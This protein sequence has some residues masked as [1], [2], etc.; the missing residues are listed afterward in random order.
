MNSDDSSEDFICDE[1]DY[2]EKEF[3]ISSWCCEVL[4]FSDSYGSSISYSAVNI[5]GRPSKFPAYGDF[6][7]SNKKLCVSLLN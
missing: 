2:E 5:C 4:D 1:I 7:V 3:E 6:A